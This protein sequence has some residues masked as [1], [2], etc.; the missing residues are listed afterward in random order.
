[1]A[2]GE[3]GLI[4]SA[5]VEIVA[6]GSAPGNAAVATGAMTTTASST[7][8]IGTYSNRTFRTF[9]FDGSM[10][11]TPTAG[12]KIDIYERALNISDTTDDANIP[13][14]AFKNRYVGS[15]ILDAGATAQ[16]IESNPVP[17][18]PYDVE[19]YFWANTISVGIAATWT[20][21]VI[22]WSY[23]TSQS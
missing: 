2:A 7:L 20:V 1:M 11:A 13:D 3:G 12:D 6:S 5:P 17:V 21:D 10:S 16:V 18:K 8:A 14:A 19:Y 4:V 15:F 9:V 23:N 22:H